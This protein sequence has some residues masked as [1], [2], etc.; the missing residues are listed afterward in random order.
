MKAVLCVLFFPSVLLAADFD[1]EIR[2]LLQERCIERLGG[3]SSVPVDV[4]WI[5]A[6][7]RDLAAQV[8]QRLRRNAQPVRI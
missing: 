6:T 3:A 4:R 5:A 7:N 2:P 8:A 1:R